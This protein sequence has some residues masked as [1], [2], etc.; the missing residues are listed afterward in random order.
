MSKSPRKAASRGLILSGGLNAP[1][2]HD[3]DEVMR[4][5]DLR[6]AAA[7]K[8]SSREL[9]RQ[10]NGVLFEHVVLAPTKVSAPLAQLHPDDAG[11]FKDRRRFEKEAD[12]K[13]TGVNCDLAKLLATGGLPA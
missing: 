10:L 6:T 2:L 11:V 8:W 9:E 7:Q 13:A 12:F 5:I 3:F 1:A 4:M